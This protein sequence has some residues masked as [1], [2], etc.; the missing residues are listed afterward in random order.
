MHCPEAHIDTFFSILIDAEQKAHFLFMTRRCHSPD[1]FESAPEPEADDEEAHVG[2]DDCEIQGMP[3]DDEIE[4]A[5][6]SEDDGWDSYDSE[7]DQV[8][9]TVEVG[10][11]VS[12]GDISEDE[13]GDGP[14]VDEDFFG[15]DEMEDNP[16]DEEGVLDN[17]VEGEEEGEME[18]DSASDTEGDNDSDDETEDDST[19]VE[20]EGESELEVDS[21]WGSVSDAEGDDGDEDDGDDDETE[22]APAADEDCVD[23]GVKE[24]DGDGDDDSD[25]QI[26]R[27][28]RHLRNVVGSD[29]DGEVTARAAHPPGTMAVFDEL[30]PG[31][32]DN[33]CE[34]QIKTL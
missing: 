33:P 14:T 16:T 30:A 9:W 8:V 5:A 25:D 6:D 15:D 11:A 24:E 1:A 4:P 18:V 2:Y 32:I 13:M 22:N 28:V 21:A 10:G 19:G 23:N 17:G 26:I 7:M 31:D 20:E 3:C 29:D 34:F 27:P 12:D